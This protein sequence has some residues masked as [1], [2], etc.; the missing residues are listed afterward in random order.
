MVICYYWGTSTGFQSK[1]DC[2]VTGLFYYRTFP[3]FF[4]IKF[5]SSKF[6]K[7]SFVFFVIYN[8]TDGVE[9]CTTPPHGVEI[10]TESLKQKI[11]KI[12]LTERVQHNPPP[13]INKSWKQN[14][15]WKKSLKKPGSFPFCFPCQI[16][17]FQLFRDVLVDYSK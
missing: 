17:S 16:F 9:N 14:S 12:F 4:I 8:S 1:L 7:K 2:F 3:T 5:F 13:F 11:Q 10:I 6:K 15:M